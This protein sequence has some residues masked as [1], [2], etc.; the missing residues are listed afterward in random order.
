MGSSDCETLA[1]FPKQGA[2]RD[3]IRLG[4]RTTGISRPDRR[5]SPQST[6][7]VILGISWVGRNTAARSMPPSSQAR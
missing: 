5:R 6:A 3:D 7:H 1:T 2:A 4:L